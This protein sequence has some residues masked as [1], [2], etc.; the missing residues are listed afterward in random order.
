MGRG[1]G[2]WAWAVGMGRGHWAWAVGMGRGHGPWAL[3]M[4]RGHGPWAW[5]T[6]PDGAA[7]PEYHV[8]HVLSGSH[9]IGTNWSSVEDQV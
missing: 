1:H 5:A 9:F 7:Q 6:A 4:G 2:P 3:G 8:H